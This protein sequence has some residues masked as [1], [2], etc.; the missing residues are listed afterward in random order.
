MKPAKKKPTPS[1]TAKKNPAGK[2]KTAA[3]VV[4]PA[5]TKPAT[6]KAPARATVAEV[7]P[8]A[9]TQKKPAQKPVAPSKPPTAKTPAKTTPKPAPAKKTAKPFAKK[10]D[11]KK[12][13]KPA[14]APVKKTV[15]PAKTNPAPTPKKVLPKKVAA[16]VK[17]TRKLPEIPAILLEGDAPDVAAKSGPGNRY[18]LGVA[19]TSVGISDD[20]LELPESYGTRRLQL[21][22]RD[23]Q[24]LYAHWDLTG[25]QLRSYNQLSRSGHLTLQ[26]F[27]N[28]IAG[29][30]KVEIEV[31]PES[32]SW[33]AHV[34]KGGGSYFAVLGFRDKL[35]QWHQITVSPKA[36]T[37]PDSL[38]DDLEAT[39][40]SIPISVSFSELIRVVQKYAA[41]EPKLAKALQL[42]QEADV[43]ELQ[44]FRTS[45]TPSMTPLR[46]T[47][48]QQQA[49]ADAVTMDE[50][51]RVWIGSEEVLELIK[52]RKGISSESAIPVGGI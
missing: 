23:P 2:K 4:K 34:G 42:L 28:E 41:N 48:A 38:S 10:S 30:P 43:P 51:R 13:V 52:G 49:L 33:F 29:S 45:S 47:Q 24:W 3:A 8:K 25:E 9:M 12:V 6:K 26:I 44:G 18:D 50:V 35:N 20:A 27:E 22:A 16:A 31:H 15:S 32:R 1:A 17:P 21:V 19:G 36:F 46:W 14:A 7:L 5:T 11:P 40:T 39:F 37:P